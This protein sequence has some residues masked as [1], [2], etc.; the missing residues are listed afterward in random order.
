VRNPSWSLNARRTK[1]AAPPVSGIAAVP[2][3]YESA[4]IRKSSP[5]PSRTH[6]VKPSASSATT[7]RAKKSDDAISPKATAASEG[8]SRTR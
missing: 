1:V 2:S 8:V 5:T 7:P 3:A 4:T 6:G